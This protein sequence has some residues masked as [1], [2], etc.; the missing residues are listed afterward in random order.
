MCNLRK[1]TYLYGHL[2]Y[3]S[4]LLQTVENI[5]FSPTSPLLVL[6]IPFTRLFDL[7]MKTHSN[8]QAEKAPYT[9]RNES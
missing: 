6:P 4:L 7:N 2:L 3:V 1:K 9:I 5:Y 8:D